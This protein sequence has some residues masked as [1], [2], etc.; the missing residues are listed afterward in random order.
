[1]TK[2]EQ[3]SRDIMREVKGAKVVA[4]QLDLADTKSICQFSENVYDSGWRA[5]TLTHMWTPQNFYKDCNAGN[6]YSVFQLKGLCIT[7]STMQVWLFALML[8]LWMDMRCSLESITWVGDENIE[9]IHQVWGS[10]PCIKLKA[11]VSQ[12]IRGGSHW[13]KSFYWNFYIPVSVFHYFSL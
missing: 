1:M 5:H 12:G 2:G 10:C 9:E 3:A 13:L 6:K 11:A 7:W 8:L 4:R